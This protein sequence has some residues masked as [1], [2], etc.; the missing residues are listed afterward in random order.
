MPCAFAVAVQFCWTRDDVFR[1]LAS[2]RR[3]CGLLYKTFTK[4]SKDAPLSMRIMQGL[5]PK[6][7]LYF[8]MFCT[9]RRIICSPQATITA[10]RTADPE[11]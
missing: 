5:I 2:W 11:R 8:F 3:V 4:S 9:L 10:V 1:G 6:H 7:V